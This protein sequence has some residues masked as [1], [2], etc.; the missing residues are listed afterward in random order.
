MP[1]EKKTKQNHSL[2]K[3]T[4]PYTFYMQSSIYF[5]TK[6]QTKPAK[7]QDKPKRKK[8]LK[9]KTNHTKKKKAEKTNT[10]PSSPSHPCPPPK[11]KKETNPNKTPL[12]HSSGFR[13]TGGKCLEEIPKASL[14]AL[15][16]NV[17]CTLNKPLNTTILT[18]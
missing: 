1:T 5:P 17:S 11:K 10:T 6:P 12:W 15:A 3:A 4:I 18:C 8:Y 2:Y 16:L 14:Y 13:D 7:T 9:N